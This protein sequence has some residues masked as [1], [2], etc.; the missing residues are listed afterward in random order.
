MTQQPYQQPQY[1]PPAP[2]QSYPAA[3]Q[4]PPQYAPPMPP[5]VQYGVPGLATGAEAQLDMSGPAFPK[6]RDLD[7]R[8]IFILAKKVKPSTDP[9]YDDQ[10]ECDVIVFDGTPITHTV[11][12]G[13]VRELAKPVQVGELL[14]NMFVGGMR[15]L[16]ALKPWVGSGQGFARRVGKDGRATI[17]VPVSEQE[18]AYVA[19]QLAGVYQRHQQQVAAGNPLAAAQAAM[20]AAQP[21]QQQPQY[22][23]PQPP[24]G[25][26]PPAPQ[27]LPP[28][29]VAPVQ[30][31]QQ[32][33]AAFDPNQWAAQQAQ[34]G[35]PG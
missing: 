34:A 33:A 22:A 7:G 17:L 19:S 9:K 23:A 31:P 3:P 27:Q 24:A 12:D 18:A 29:P 4:P 25:Y 20:T 16:P 28:P 35:Q 32:V 10:L 1:A 14:E 6:L 26:V 13:K 2:P 5:P 15:L 21:V 8:L 30:P 11:D